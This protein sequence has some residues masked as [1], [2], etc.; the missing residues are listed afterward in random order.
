MKQ[1]RVDQILEQWVEERPDLDPSALGVVGRILR[2][3]K[4]VRRGM[5]E[6]LAPYGLDLWGFDVLATLRRAGSPYSLSPTDLRRIVMLTSGA[7][8][9]RIDRLEEQGWVERVA[10]PNDR[11]AIQVRLTPAGKEL[12]DEAV[13]ARLEVAE[14]LVEPLSA[15]DR[16]RLADL[17][18]TLLVARAGE[19]LRPLREATAARAR[20][21]D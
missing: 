14:N 20:S 11:R 8:T 5:K 2:L 6:S 19:E 4:H 18:R 17:L 3:A 15:T 13:V 1:D 21:F 7:M 16:L 9:N 12:I 10:D